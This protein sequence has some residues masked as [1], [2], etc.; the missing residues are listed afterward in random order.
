MTKDRYSM[1]RM[2]YGGGQITSA[3]YEDM[4]QAVLR[5]AYS[6]EIRE[7]ARET[8][9]G[10][11]DEPSAEQWGNTPPETKA[12]LKP[13]DDLDPEMAAAC[14]KICEVLDRLDDR[15]TAAEAYQQES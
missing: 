3:Q 7:I 11:S 4:L 8:M 15:L 5:G 14:E 1:S 2:D 10:D 13:D 12:L 9:R 6:R